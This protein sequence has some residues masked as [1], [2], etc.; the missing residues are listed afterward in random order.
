MPLYMDRHDLPGLTTEGI[1]EAH[2]MDL[3]IQAQYGCNAMT[4]WVDSDRS[5]VFCLIDAPS[6]HA[7]I[8]MHNNSHGKI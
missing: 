5:Y 8:E 3:S 6:I 2:Q 4:Y 1:A 7:V